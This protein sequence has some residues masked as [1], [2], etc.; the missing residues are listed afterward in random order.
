MDS[1]ISSDSDSI[2]KQISSVIKNFSQ[3]LLYQ[4]QT[5]NTFLDLSKESN[6]L[7]NNWGAQKSPA[8][9]FFFQGPENAT[10]F[11]IDSEAH[12]FTGE[13]G[14]LLIKILKA[15]KLSSDSIFICN[16][17]DLKSVHEKI[18]TICPEMIITL[19]AKAGKSLLKIERPLEEFRGKFYEYKGIKVMPTFHP[20]RLLRQPEY[21]RQVWE[22]MKCVMEKAGLKYDS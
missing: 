14:A 15:M 1:D 18:K 17:D 3:Y 2:K 9:K 22:D 12:F 6:T 7:I 16:S 4:K 5:G 13:S 10:I 8:Q 20:S 21:K 19:G 11:I